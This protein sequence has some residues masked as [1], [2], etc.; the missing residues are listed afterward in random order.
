[1]E[2]QKELNQFVA[3]KPV[4]PE[5]FEKVRGNSVLQLPGSWETNSA[6]LGSLQE[7]I[8][9]NLGIAYLDN[10]AAML[11]NMQLANVQQA[12]KRVIQPKALTWV[13]VGDRA[14]VEAGIQELNIG[15]IKYIDSEGKEI[16]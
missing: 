9:Y 15:P 8:R 11:Q 10:Y 16:K 14:K 12:A 3:D 7:V 2:L 13:I 1:M 6:V 5:E 4:T